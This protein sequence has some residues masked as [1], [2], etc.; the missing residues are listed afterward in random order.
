[1]IVRELLTRLGFQ[2]DEKGADKYEQR[3]GRVRS[4][5]Q[6]ISRLMFAGFGVFAGAGLVGQ[7]TRVADEMTDYASRVKLAIGENENL[8]GTMERLKD[9]AQFTY[10]DFNTT[11]E[12][13]L[14]NNNALREMGKTTEE[15]LNYTQA[16]NDAF[17][18]SGTKGD[19][20]ARVQ[21]QLSRAMNQG[22]LRG[23]EFNAVVESGGEILELLKR[24]M[25]ALNTGELKEMAKA[26]QITGEVLYKTMIAAMDE[27]RQKADD[28]PATFADARMRMRTE[29]GYMVYQINEASGFT[30]ALGDGVEYV[31]EM[32]VSW[33]PTIIAAVTSLNDFAE[34]LG[35]WPSILQSVA[36]GLMALAGPAVIRGLL[37][38]AGTLTKFAWP[39]VLI[40]ALGLALQ[41]LYSWLKGKESV[42]GLIFGDVEKYTEDFNKIR[43]GLRS[44]YDGEIGQGLKELGEGLG[45]IFDKASESF[46]SFDRRFTSWF[47]NSDLGQWFAEQDR[48]LLNAWAHFGA[49][50]Q[51]LVEPAFRNVRRWANGALNYVKG[52]W[53]AATVDWASIV[54]AA[55]DIFDPLRPAFD[56]AIETLKP[57]WEAFIRWVENNV[58]FIGW[59]L[60]VYRWMNQGGTS[61]DTSDMQGPP[62]PTSRDRAVDWAQRY[63]GGSG[64]SGEDMMRMLGSEEHQERLKNWGYQPMSHTPSPNIDAGGNTF[65]IDLRMPEG[66][67]QQ[68]VQALSAGLE[69]QVERV[70]SRA[71]RSSMNDFPDA[72]MA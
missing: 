10:S 60:Q 35:G 20:A 51:S 55:S 69:A 16:L 19:Q 3:L 58:P 12:S 37:I 67:T 33:T 28:M 66:T 34:A 23:E 39:L 29:I 27:L 32:I 46:E 52:R 31:R 36:F 5:A 70:L 65:N 1:M 59:G 68:Q 24:E 64:L 8:A 44:I 62:A 9:L 47:N 22:V 38:L 18:V 7:F 42:F 11:A 54:A 45:G 63:G 4:Q 40:L 49:G 30:Y 25:G 17:V 26:G 13:F 53:A 15:A 14:L 6:M 43:D 21:I 72:E 61:Q 56:R 2:V 71:V 57:Q 48:K 50:M 41:D